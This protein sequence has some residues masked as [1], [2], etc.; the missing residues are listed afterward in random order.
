MCDLSK[1]R[2][3]KQSRVKRLHGVRPV[4]DLLCSSCWILVKWTGI[5]VGS[6]LTSEGMI[7]GMCSCASPENSCL[8]PWGVLGVIGLTPLMVPSEGG[9]VALSLRTLAWLAP[10]AS[11]TSRDGTNT[12]PLPLAA[13]SGCEEASVAM[14]SVVPAGPGASL[15]SAMTLGIVGVAPESVTLKEV[16]V[17]LVVMVVVVDVMAVAEAVAAA[18]ELVVDVVVVV[19]VLVVEVLVSAL[20]LASTT[21]SAAVGVVAVVVVFEVI[22]EV[23]VLVAVLVVV[24]EVVVAAAVSAVVAF[25]EVVV[26]AV[27]VI[28]EVVSGLEA[29]F[30]FGLTEPLGLLPTFE[31]GAVKDSI[32]AVEIVE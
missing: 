30:G 2:E 4:S 18:V 29:V 17:E 31:E 14:S 16:V 27:A 23:V 15:L 20:V 3:R 6:F 12:L 28:V 7:R 1:Q 21:V 24:V 5:S 22:A 8:L 32:S 9:L 11:I 26:V 13:A 10:L 25:V 19:A